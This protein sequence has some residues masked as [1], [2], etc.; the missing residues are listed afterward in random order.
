L[1]LRERSVRVAR[2]YLVLGELQHSVRAVWQKQKE[3]PCLVRVAWRYLVL[4]ALPVSAEQ[5]CPVQGAWQYPVLGEL[6]HLVP[7]VWQ[8]QGARQH[9]VLGELQH[10]VLQR[11][12]R[13]ARK[14]LGLAVQQHPAQEERP[15]QGPVAWSTQEE[16]PCLVQEVREHPERA[17]LQ[18]SAPQERLAQAVQQHPERAELQHWAPRERPVPEAWQAQAEL[19]G[20]ASS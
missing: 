15:H 11:S 2:R 14:Y 7:A 1:V 20:R 4:T 3:Q 6:Q 13:V 19:W 17:E 9:P 18:H 10:L 8:V 16:P 5:L 12:A